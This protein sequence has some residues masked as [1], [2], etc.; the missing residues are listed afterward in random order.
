M[1]LILEI[2]DERG[3]STLHRLATLPLTIGRALSND[4]ILDDPY[5][6][7]R[8]ARIALDESGAAAIDDLGTVNGLLADGAR[9]NGRATVLAGTEVRIG[10][11]VLRFRD[12]DEVVAPALV[13]DRRSTVVAETSEVVAAGGTNDA[14]PAL[15]TDHPV[16][17]TLL[18]R[19]LG[20][21]SGRRWIIALM[22]AGF[23][24]NHWLGNT[25]R[26][27]AGPVMWM[28]ITVTG[29]ASIW[30]LLWTLGGPRVNRQSRFVV[31]L[32]VVSLALL[33]MLVVESLQG[34]LSFLFPDAVV[35]SI[36][37]SAAFLVV[38]GG[39]V[40]GHMWVSS[41]LSRT[42]MWRVGL[43]AVGTSVVLMLV[44]FL[45]NEEKFSDVPSF[46]R[47]L[48]P[49]PAA[50]VPARTVLEFGP[51]MRELKDEVDEKAAK[52]A[53]N[54]VAADSVR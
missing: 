32:A 37:Y 50:W 43:I 29:M 1:A 21:K 8:H 4:I 49:V 47:D 27:S 30:A 51:V 19:L 40:A 24:L 20:A 53:K 26:S 5:L 31:H 22:I 14:A 35:V 23:A 46:E 36:A 28:A 44:A 17:A 13:D 52:A 3:V 15:Q 12:V 18:P 38:I 54:D 10:R 48:K 45:V 34:W 11:T 6:D 41:A 9:V 25:N 2:L 16:R 42:A 33:A 7:A 39:N